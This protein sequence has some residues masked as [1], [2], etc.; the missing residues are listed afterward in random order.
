MGVQKVADSKSVRVCMSCLQPFM[1]ELRSVTMSHDQ[2]SNQF[3]CF[4]CGWEQMGGK[5]NELRLWGRRA[6]G[7]AAYLCRGCNRA[8]WREWVDIHH[9]GERVTSEGYREFAVAHACRWRSYGTR[10]HFR[11]DLVVTPSTVKS[12]TE[13]E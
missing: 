11:G 2:D 9:E 5:W 1:S 7:N 10:F 6:S 8:V 4:Y 3:V 13:L 12:R